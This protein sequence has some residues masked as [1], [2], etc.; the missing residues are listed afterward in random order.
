MTISTLNID[1]ATER[2][3]SFI[4][5]LLNKRVVSPVLRDKVEGAI[6]DR[7]TASHF[8]SLLTDL[9]YKRHNYETTETVLFEELP[10]GT[11]TVTDGNGGWVTLRTRRESWAENKVVIS[12]LTSVDGR[13]TYKKFGFVTPQGIKPFSTE[14]NNQRAIN[15][16]KF[17][18][19]SD[20]NNARTEFLNQ[21]EALA[22]E[23]GRC[24]RCLK[25]LTVPTSLFRGLGPD[26]AS[27]MGLV[28]SN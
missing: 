9:P 27:E 5:D 17:L 16:G 22:L 14:R 1:N 21:A 24:A 20:I 26:C 7:A 10:I 8:I 6:L 15:A 23:S 28:R 11:F 25:T 19:T 3:V 12:Y 18:L 2:Q 13:L 4:E